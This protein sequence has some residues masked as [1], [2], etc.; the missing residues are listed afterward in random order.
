MPLFITPQH[1]SQWNLSSI[2]VYIFYHNPNTHSQ[3]QTKKM[4]QAFAYSSSFV[5]Y[6]V[7]Q[8]FATIY[9]A[10]IENLWFKIILC[11]IWIGKYFSYFLHLLLIFFSS[12][13][14]FYFIF[15]LRFIHTT[16]ISKSTLTPRNH[17]FQILFLFQLE[18]QWKI[19]FF[20][21][22]KCYNSF[23]RSELFL[24]FYSQWLSLFKNLH[25]HFISTIKE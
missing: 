18:I 23:W 17:K 24:N 4:F 3:K 12:C 15:H 5:S 13:F 6:F 19:M 11:R 25:F 21:T 14:D 22:I 7:L 1:S 9:H 20:S 2:P 8:I 10:D 16:F